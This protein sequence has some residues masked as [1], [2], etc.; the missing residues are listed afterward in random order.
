[1]TKWRIEAWGRTLLTLASFAAVPVMGGS[2]PQCPPGPISFALYEHGHFYDM[3]R[4]RGIDRDVA[5]VLARRSGCR[6]EFLPRARPRIWHDLQSGALMM[7][8][9]AIPTEE[10]SELAWFVPYL[11]VKNYV[12]VRASLPIGSAREFIASKHLRWGAVRS[13]RYGEEADRFLEALRA[14]G[15]LA[16]DG[17]LR[18]A[19]RAFAKGRTDAIF[20]QPY[21]L[22]L[23]LEAHSAGE[24]VRVLDWFP[25]DPPVIGALAFSKHFFTAEQVGAVAMTGSAVATAERRHFAHFVTYM[26]QKNFVVVH[27][28]VP[29]RSAAEFF[30]GSEA[31]WGAVRGYRHGVRADQYLE[32]L[33]RAGRLAEAADIGEVFR[34]FARGRTA[35]LLAPPATYARYLGEVLDPGRVRI[36]DWFP[37]DLPIPH[38]LAFSRQ[39]FSE[40]AIEGWRRMLRQ[41]REDGSLRNIYAH[42]LGSE[43]AARL[44]AFTPD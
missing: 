5:E 35:A 7:T 4:D 17:D 18:A 34:L 8:G 31:R 22:N 24:A 42:Y 39:H 16:E 15:R 14:E 33:R 44:L 43:D 37:A 2:L 6:F 25:E 32:T 10:R 26:T 9:S 1:M 12:L 20:I 38:A 23:Y 36:E 19:F 40:E 27:R 3:K 28:A 30:A 41:M 13:Y 21:V 11:A 29:A